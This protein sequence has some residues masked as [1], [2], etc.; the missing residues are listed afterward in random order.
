M[1][2]QPPEP[3]AHPAAPCSWRPFDLVDDEVLLKIFA[4]LAP[5]TLIRA[6]LVC[7]EWYGQ[8]ND[9]ELWARLHN[10]WLVERAQMH[11]L[12]A[13]QLFARAHFTAEVSRT[14]SVK[15]LKLVIAQRR[16]GARAAPLREKAEL[17]TLVATSSYPPLSARHYVLPS[18]W[19]AS[20]A[21]AWA[22]TKRVL[23][24]VD[25]LVDIDW[26]FTFHERRQWQGLDEIHSRFYTDNTY[27]SDFRPNP[28]QQGHFMWRF[29]AGGRL[30]VHEFPPFDT[31]RTKQGGWR[32]TN[33]IGTFTCHDRPEGCAYGPKDTAVGS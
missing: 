15:Q 17:A 5:K 8:S 20:F 19:K 14:L 24:T 21:Y 12:R 18:K 9:D 33:H 7:R 22:D 1:E 30:Q 6:G 29:V 3:Q 25:D 31:L 28:Q 11:R 2:P 27:W 26:V 16:L 23:M 4:L 32:L 13:D 10:L